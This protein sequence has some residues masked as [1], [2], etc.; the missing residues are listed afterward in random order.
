MYCGSSLDHSDTPPPSDAG[1]TRTLCPEE[2]LFKAGDR[3]T[4]A[5]RVES[6]VICLYNPLWNGDKAL[7]EFISPG[8]LVGLGFLDHHIVTARALVE[9][10][11][12]GL[13]SSQVNE[14][15]A[16]NTR[17][18]ARLA[19]AIEREFEERRIQLGD[20]AEHRPVERFAA[21]LVN[22][23]CSNAYEGRDPH[24]IVDCSDCGTIADMLDLSVAELTDI[25]VELER[26]KL[27]EPDLSG[28]LR[29][30]DID[31]LEVLADGPTNSADRIFVY[32]QHTR[33]PAL[34]A[35]WPVAA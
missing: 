28:G 23:S 1:V 34:P 20:T 27:V 30:K 19:A 12:T 11:L 33:P 26:R 18:E 15:M 2:V 13:T 29:L 31:A 25:L 16:T 8:D 5:Y 3:K 21:L 24:L 7:V 22:L 9:T 32:E 14:I 6:G 10:R 17:Q 4:I 35:R